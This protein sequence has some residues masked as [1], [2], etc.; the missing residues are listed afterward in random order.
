MLHLSKYLMQWRKASPQQQK[1]IYGNG[2][3][4][5]TL[6]GEGYPCTSR[7]IVPWI[8][9]V[10]LPSQA[11]CDGCKEEGWTSGTPITPF[12]VPALNSSLPEK[13]L[14]TSP[15]EIDSF[16]SSL[17]V[18]KIFLEGK[19]PSSD[20]KVV[21]E[22]RSTK[23]N[24]DERCPMLPLFYGPLRAVDRSYGPYDKP[25]ALLKVRILS[26]Y[27][28]CILLLHQLR[29]SVLRF[30]RSLRIVTVRMLHWYGSC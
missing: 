15:S 12:S 28:E 14:P 8:L 9:E 25:S 29:R 10:F 6:E 20:D 24:L 11:T 17:Q 18:K 19:L 7:T 4:L 5:K 1:K 30:V 16:L 2:V 21:Q 27:G 23:L 26:T 22:A 13:Y 3:N